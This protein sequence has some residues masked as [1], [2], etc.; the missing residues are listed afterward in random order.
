MVTGPRALL[1]GAPGSSRNGGVREGVREAEGRRV[2][3]A[4]AELGRIRAQSSCA[5]HGG[6]NN[7]LFFL[8][9]LSLHRDSRICGLG[10]WKNQRTWGHG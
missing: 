7:P 2:G 6:E 4:E 3:S 5:S 9:A 8:T 10:A 1:G